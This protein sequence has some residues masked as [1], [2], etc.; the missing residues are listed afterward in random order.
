MGQD[1]DENDIKAMLEDLDTTNGN[2]IEFPAFLTMMTRKVDQ[3]DLKNEILQVW[4][5]SL[6]NVI[7]CVN[8]NSN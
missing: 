7:F 4:F 2:T 5:L 6:L 3:K 8:L 1:I